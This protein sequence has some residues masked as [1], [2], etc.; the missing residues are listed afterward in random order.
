MIWTYFLF[1]FDYGSLSLIN[2][3]R[4]CLFNQP[5][6]SER[7]REGEE[8]CHFRFL[9]PWY[10]LVNFSRHCSDRRLCP[11]VSFTLDY[12]RVIV[13]SCCYSLN[14][15]RK[16]KNTKEPEWRQIRIITTRERTES[17]SSS[18][19][20]IA[21]SSSSLDRSA[22]WRL[23]IPMYSQ[24]DFSPS[25]SL[26]YQA[27]MCA[28][29][30]EQNWIRS[31]VCMFRSSLSLSLARA[32]SFPRLSFFSL[33]DSL[34]FL[35]SE[36]HRSWFLDWNNTRR[37]Q[38]EICRLLFHLHY[39]SFSE[40]K[41]RR[42]FCSRLHSLPECHTSQFF[43]QSNISQQATVWWNHHLHCLQFNHARLFVQQRF[44]HRLLRWQWWNN[45]EEY[46]TIHNDR[47]EFQSWPATHENNLYHSDLYNAR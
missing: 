46:E 24:F 12:S 27:R 31:S 20:F 11:N 45:F 33:V 14:R 6:Q 7:Q 8:K 22:G 37:Y 13:Q 16:R 3:T 10:H 17:F 40:W 36:I 18:M 26:C 39:A 9:F 32:R 4:F 43:S 47:A 25:S 19:L 42:R 1:W 34:L 44:Y 30:K 23:F 41:Y 29:N 28:C 38:N 5:G 35:P 15:E 21:C 2:M